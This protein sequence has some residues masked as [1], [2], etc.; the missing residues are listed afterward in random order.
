MQNNTFSTAF[1][2][3]NFIKLISV[4]STNDYLKKLTSNSEP[5]PEG[6]VIMAEYQHA[7][8]GQ[9]ESIW[10]TEP[11][12]NLTFSVF[13]QPLFIS[14]SNTFYLNI[15]VSLA[16]NKALS[17]YVKADLTIKWPNDIYFK[18]KKLGGILIENAIMGS[19]LKH[20]IIGIGINVNQKSFEPILGDKPISLTQILQ[21]E[22]A[23]TSL[24]NEICIELERVYIQMREGIV[25]NWSEMYTEK[26]YRLGVIAQYSH[27]NETFEGRILGITASGLLKIGLL[28][29]TIRTFGFKE[30]SFL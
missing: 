8:R 20:T 21:E 25:S 26:L 24:L 3:Q 11:Q 27:N 6:T 19:K 16:I 29:G 22:I 10:L 18:D 4:N 30:V 15:L 1:L 28:D 14:P 13:L 7:G 12:K 9:R 17:K 5:L 2:G 23:L